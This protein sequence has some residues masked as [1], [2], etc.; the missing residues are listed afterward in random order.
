MRCDGLMAGVG[1][2]ASMGG[3]QRGETIFNIRHSIYV[4]VDVDAVPLRVRATCS[5]RPDG[6]LLPI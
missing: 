3:G 6:E 4:D 5:P 1:D 2:V